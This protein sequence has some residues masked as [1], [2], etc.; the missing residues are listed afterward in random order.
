MSALIPF[1]SQGTNEKLGNQLEKP[2]DLVQEKTLGEN[3]FFQ[4]QGGTIFVRLT[5]P[6]ARFNPS[7]LRFNPESA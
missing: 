7:L 3:K 4:K 1:P 2:T 6:P 5:L